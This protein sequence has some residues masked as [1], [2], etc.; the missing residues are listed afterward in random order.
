MLCLVCDLKENTLVVEYLPKNAL[1][2]KIPFIPQPEHT[3]WFRNSTGLYQ[4]I[5]FKVRHKRIIFLV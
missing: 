2:M 3:D 5:Y 4:F 1:T